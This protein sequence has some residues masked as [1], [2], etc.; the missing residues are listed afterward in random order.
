MKKQG[1]DV[2]QL[3]VT[4]DYNEAKLAV[5]AVANRFNR[6]CAITRHDGVYIVGTINDG[7]DVLMLI[8]YW[9]QGF[10]GG[11]QYTLQ[12]CNRDTRK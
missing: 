11:R 3:L 12:E 7:T 9:I 8:S 5:N 6:E 10:M 2:F 1:G 4:E